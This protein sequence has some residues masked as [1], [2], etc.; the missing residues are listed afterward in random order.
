MSKRIPLFNSFV[1]VINGLIV[2]IYLFGVFW[3]PDITLAALLDIFLILG[4]CFRFSFA[5]TD[6]LP[7]W[8]IFV[9]LFFYVAV[10]LDQL[11]NAIFSTKSLSEV[12]NSSSGILL[13]AL[14]SIFLL[15]TFQFKKNNNHRKT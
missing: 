11:S 7:K 6:E 4:L 3:Y 13:F 2:S 14:V 9:S 12:L 1:V 10:F 5:I 15:D 8:K